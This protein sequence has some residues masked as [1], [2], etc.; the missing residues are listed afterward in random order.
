MSSI[1]LSFYWGGN[2]TRY[3]HANYWVAKLSDTILT[4]MSVN[5]IND[6]WI[7]NRKFK[8]TRV[9]QFEENVICSSNLQPGITEPEAISCW[10]TSWCFNSPP[11]SERGLQRTEDPYKHSPVVL[12]LATRVRIWP[13]HPISLPHVRLFRENLCNFLYRPQKAKWSSKFNHA[14]TLRRDHKL[15]RFFCFLSN[16]TQSSVP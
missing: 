10:V 9:G 15:N 4:F 13:I 1:P 7:R 2:T 8:R 3:I 6:K 14:T 5:R 11:A 16:S 12:A